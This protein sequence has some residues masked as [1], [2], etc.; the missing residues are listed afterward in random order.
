MG[1][2]RV[3][4]RTGQ[5]LDADIIFDDAFIRYFIEDYEQN[6]A[7][8]LYGYN[9]HDPM[10]EKFLSENPEW[11]FRP[12]AQSLIPDRDGRTAGWGRLCGTPPDGGRGI[13]TAPGLVY[14][15]D[16]TTGGLRWNRR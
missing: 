7:N 9:E 2:S 15:A 4:P 8:T 3:H 1:P 16:K 12:R 5:I 10:L 6:K 11:Q 13:L 14:H